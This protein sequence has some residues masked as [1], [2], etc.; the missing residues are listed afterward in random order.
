VHCRFL[1]TRAQHDQ[2]SARRIQEI[3]GILKA[4]EADGSVAADVAAL[5]GIAHSYGTTYSAVA[6]TALTSAVKQQP[7]NGR[8]WWALGTTLWKK[9]GPQSRQ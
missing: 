9:V 8:A 5:R 3:E 1:P 2:E 4:V 6:E 7:T